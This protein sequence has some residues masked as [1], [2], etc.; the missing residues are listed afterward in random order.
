[1]FIDSVGNE[2]PL[3][4]SAASLLGGVLTARGMHAEARTCLLHA[5]RVESTKDGV[6]PTPLYE[7]LS[8]LINLHTRSDA[9][10]LDAQ[11]L[12]DARPHIHAAVANLE[13]RGALD[14]GNAG[15]L[16][17]KMGE[18]L[19]FSS[20]AHAG[21][22]VQL[23]E[24]ARRLLKTEATYDVSSLLEIID[25]ELEAAQ[26]HLAPAAEPVPGRPAPEPPLEAPEPQAA[27][28]SQAPSASE[29][30]DESSTKQR[31]ARLEAENQALRSENSRLREALRTV[32][33]AVAD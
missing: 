12:E 33:L 23:L 25:L 10:S 13:A 21:E 29:A 26:Y 17:H 8:Q 2:S 11:G 30:A 28:Q 18:A 19:L 20:T 6:H 24:R 3:T 31:M 9:G 5:L 16:L 14:D 15:V 27:E 22:A 4:G 32:K 7:L 1:M